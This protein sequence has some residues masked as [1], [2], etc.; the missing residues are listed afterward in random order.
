VEKKTPKKK[1]AKNWQNRLGGTFFEG[2]PIAPA[3]GEEENV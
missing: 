1:H 3:D 2:N